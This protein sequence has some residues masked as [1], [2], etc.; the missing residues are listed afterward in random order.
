MAHR[1]VQ[2]SGGY[3]P[4]PRHDLSRGLLDL[5]PCPGESLECNPICGFLVLLLAG[6]S[7]RSLLL[8]YK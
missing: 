4:S 7:T 6:I 1:Q 3:T 2:E 5:F 8:L